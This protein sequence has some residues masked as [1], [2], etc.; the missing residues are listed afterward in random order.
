MYNLNSNFKRILELNNIDVEK[1]TIEKDGKLSCGSM[2]GFGK[3]QYS[4]KD[5]IAYQTCC[6]IDRN[7]DKIIIERQFKLVNDELV[8]VQEEII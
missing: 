3:W 6:K 4:E 2:Y 8:K 1:A 5:G 7:D